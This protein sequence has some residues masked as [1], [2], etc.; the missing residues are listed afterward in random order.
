MSGSRGRKRR[1]ALPDVDSPAAPP[2]SNAELVFSEPWESRAIG[3]AVSLYEEALSPGR[4]PGRTHR[5]DRPLARRADRHVA[6]EL[7]GRGLP[8]KPWRTG[9][10]SDQ[11]HCKPRESGSGQMPK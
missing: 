4:N 5:P 7:L 1:L 11:S 10:M 9:S 2:R 6:A 3:M 8:V